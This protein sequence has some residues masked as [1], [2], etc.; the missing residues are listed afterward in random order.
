MR[1]QT[2]HHIIGQFDEGHPGPL[3]F[4]MGGIH[5]NEP[6]GLRALDLLL[7][8]LEVEH[9]TNTSFQFRG[10]LMALMGNTRAVKAKKRYINKDLNR[11]F[12]TDR[13]NTWR[14]K[15][16][17]KYEEKEAVEL[18]ELVEREIQNYQ[19]SEV[20]ILDLHTTTA[21]GGIFTIVPEDLKALSLGKALKAPVVEGFLTG[22][23]GTILHYFNSN[24][25]GIPTQTLCF[26]A[27][28]HED[29]LSVNRSIAAA[30]N[31]LSAIQCVDSFHI[32]SQHNKIL[33]Q[34][35]KGLPEHC[36]LVYT[37]RIVKGDGFSMKPGFH[38][39]D[40]VEKGQRLASD[41]KG[42]I[43]ARCSG[44][45]LMPHYQSQGED[46]FFIIQE[47]SPRTIG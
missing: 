21:T 18:V 43:E 3:V 23:R 13:I 31:F 12:T 17:L 46:G 16:H 25:L 39:F 2:N 15:I 14:R 20:F 28:Q 9:I 7:K 10:K 37:H 44:R 24:N 32:E 38:N 42:A 40:P 8:M 30:V 26:E 4:I 29:P 5:G 41:H 35:A 45:I 19:P 27:G 22:I 47:M 34:Y 11:Q 36:R 1:I 33:N 6:A